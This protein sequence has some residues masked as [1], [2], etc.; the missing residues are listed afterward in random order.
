MNLI[1]VLDASFRWMLILKMEQG[2]CDSLFLTMIGEHSLMQQLRAKGIIIIISPLKR[3]STIYG[4]P[5]E[6]IVSRILLN[7]HLSLD[8]GIGTRS[9]PCLA[10]PSLDELAM[11]AL[12]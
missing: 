1:S 8:T 3:R 9:L 12:F 10:T 5:V 2:F 4:L 6:E 11:K 7:S